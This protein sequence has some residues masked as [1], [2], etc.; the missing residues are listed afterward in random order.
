MKRF[1]VRALWALAA[2][3]LFGCSYAS[4]PSYDFMAKRPTV[5]LVYDFQA[6]P[7][8]VFE[9]PGLIAEGTRN[10]GSASRRARQAAIG[11]QI[12]MRIHQKLID[13]I[14]SLGLPAQ[15]GDPSRPAAAGALIIRGEFWT[16]SPDNLQ[17]RDIV[18]FGKERSTVDTSIY[19]LGVISPDKL[20]PLLHFLTEARA[21]SMPAVMEDNKPRRA[22][23]ASSRERGQRGIESVTLDTYRS[24]VDQLADQSVSQAIANLSQYFA[25]RGWIS[26]SQVTTPRL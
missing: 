6:S 17:I 4:Q 11:Q 9:D 19:A 14:N 16:A 26:G 2:A 1:K 8:T 5:V 3:A 20:V 23:T 12:R 24:Q 7:N 13:G 15:P 25:N 18:Q 22:A 21:G 10:F